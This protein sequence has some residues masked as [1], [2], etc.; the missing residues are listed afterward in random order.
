MPGHWET[1]SAEKTVNKLNKL[2]ELRSL[3]LHV[4]EVEK[5]GFQIRIGD[6]DYRLLD[7]DTQRNE[8]LEELGKAKYTDL[9]VLVYRMQLTYDEIID[10]L[11]LKYIPTK[12]QVNL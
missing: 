10:I 11:D 8:I 6:K 12:E 4:K 5:R 3:E 2:L 9:E 1:K 7:F